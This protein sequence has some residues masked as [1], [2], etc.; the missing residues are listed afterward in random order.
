M[1]TAY[2]YQEEQ[3][4]AYRFFPLGWTYAQPLFYQLQ[5]G[6]INFIPAPQSVTA[7]TLNYTP[8]APQLAGD[9]STIDDINGW[10]E[11]MVLDA[12]IKA[13]TKDGQLDIIPLLQQERQMQRQRIEGA[14]ATRDR[15]GERAHL[16][17]DFYNLDWY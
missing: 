15:V 4:N 9:G 11:W 3:R 7:V 16:R 10:A 12:A 13:L 17:E 8:V 6:T 5:G 14:A 1:L 2:P